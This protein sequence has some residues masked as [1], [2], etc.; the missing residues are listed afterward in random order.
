MSF[1]PSRTMVDERDTGF[2]VRSSRHGSI[3][4]KSGRDSGVG[5]G[6]GERDEKGGDD[7]DVSQ[8]GEH[9]RVDVRNLSIS[10]DCGV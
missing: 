3:V 8:R 1:A 7:R 9:C 4:G 10:L 5:D 6:A 2:I